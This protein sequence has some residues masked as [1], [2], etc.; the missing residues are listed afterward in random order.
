MGPK[1]VVVIPACC[2]SVC[3]GPYPSAAFKVP[4][5][6]CAFET[7]AVTAA[8]I[9]AGLDKRGDRDA[10]VITLAGDGG[11][12]DI[13]LQS[14]SGAA[15]RNDNIIY[16]CYDNEAYMNT[17]IQRSSSTPTEAITTTT[18]DAAPKKE[19]KK[20]IL[21][22]MA[23]HRVPYIASATIAYPKDFRKKLEKAKEIEGFRFI[24]AFSPCPTGWKFDPKYSMKMAKLAVNAGIFPLLEI[25]DREVKWTRTPRKGKEEEA[26]EEYM[27]LQ[28][29]FEFD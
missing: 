2:L 25:E 11:T 18:P 28:R 22:I 13:G 26:V 7:A 14:L 15:E 29:R 4:V 1:T 20:D 16:I 27:K 6:N 5:V 17:G 3:N 10:H 8:G 21:S 23:A 19:F 12:Y 24:L 9:R